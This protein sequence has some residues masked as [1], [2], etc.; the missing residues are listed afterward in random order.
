MCPL[1]QR[2]GRAACNFLITAIAL[3]LVEPMYFDK[4]KE[5]KAARKVQREEKA[6]AILKEKV[7]VE[8]EGLGKRKQDDRSVDVGNQSRSSPHQPPIVHP[9]T[10]TGAGA[11]PTP[12]PDSDALLR[13]QFIATT[14]S[15]TT[16]TATS[17]PI[18]DPQSE[19]EN[20]D[21]DNVVVDQSIL[22]EERCLLYHGLVGK[23]AEK[24]THK[25]KRRKKDGNELSASMDDTINA[26]A[27]GRCFSCFRA[28]ADLYFENGRAGE[29]LPLYTMD[30]SKSPSLR[31][32]YM[33]ARFA[34]WVSS[35]CIPDICGVL[36]AL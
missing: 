10:A 27:P 18:S 8:K 14:L 6:R 29:S 34:S 28:P 19:D 4:T 5:E 9:S 31:Q 15:M 12:I 33:S 22:L 1:W 20:S 21:N 24:G 36:R 32:F 13:S 16:S 25:R 2:F 23:E 3:F 35:L 30:I 11:T 26:G 7:I 17:H